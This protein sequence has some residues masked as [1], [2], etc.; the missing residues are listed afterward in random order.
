[1]IQDYELKTSGIQI[2]VNPTAGSGKAKQIADSLLP[3]IR[4]IS[5]SNINLIFTKG[6]D[7]ATFIARDAIINGASM[8]I[9]V[10]GDGT[11]NEI[12]NGFFIENK[13]I[14]PLCDL[15]IIS[16]GTGR[17]IGGGFKLPKSISQQVDLI[18]HCKS[19]PVDVGHISYFNTGG[20]H[21]ERLFINECQT[22]IGSKVASAVG[23][24]QKVWGGT[25]AFGLTSTLQVLMLKPQSLSIRF[26]DEPAS[27]FNLIGVVAGNGTECAGGM[28]LTPDAK[29]DDGLFD[30]LLMHEMNVIKR[31]FNLT[32][33]YSGSHILSPYFTIRR[34]K[35][36]DITS[37]TK[38]TIEADGEVLGFSPF[39]I[40]IIPA[41][42]RIKTGFNNTD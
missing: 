35:R 31:L 11:V 3:E 32:K 12:V 33:V 20:K 18:V 30:V 38:T 19:M 9:A 28:K 8:I 10:G 24:K 40:E 36:L 39:S 25:V 29:I 26:D 2:I 15:G 13:P 42:I 14:N 16:C 23:K 21:A 17:G 1:L 34:C 7:D 22:G 37:D 5:D 27:K 6:K 4:S 41:S